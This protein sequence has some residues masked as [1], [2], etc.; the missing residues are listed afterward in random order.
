MTAGDV[1]LRESFSLIKNYP[2]VVLRRE[3]E[4]KRI[5]TRGGDWRLCWH[6]PRG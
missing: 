4:W 2:R 5:N 3:Y 1:A 6:R